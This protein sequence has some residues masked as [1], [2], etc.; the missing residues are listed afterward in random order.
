[1]FMNEMLAKILE[2]D[3]ISRK[4]A[5]EAEEAKKKAFDELTMIRASL[6]EKKLA[7][8]QKM[9][10]DMRE[11]ELDKAAQTAA[12]LKAKNEAAKEKLQAVYAENRE[13][14]V[15]ELYSRVIE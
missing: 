2:M 12:G 3:K 11:K 7:E 1:M 9:I 6:I 15:E 13:K 10:A 4:Q 5:E 8:A 14:W